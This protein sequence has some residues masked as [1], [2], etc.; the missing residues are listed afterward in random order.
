LLVRARRA[1]VAQERVVDEGLQRRAITPK[2]RVYSLEHSTS[3]SSGLVRP[4]TV[5]Q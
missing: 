5:A 2:A 1:L 4:R 3:Q